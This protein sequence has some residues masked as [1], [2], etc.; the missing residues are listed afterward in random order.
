MVG[1][2]M[3]L[4]KLSRLSKAGACLVIH[5]KLKGLKRMRTKQQKSLKLS[6]RLFRRRKSNRPDALA[7]FV[8]NILLKQENIFHNLA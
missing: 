6:W 1:R 4:Q 7:T 8:S 2:N 5:A 3:Y